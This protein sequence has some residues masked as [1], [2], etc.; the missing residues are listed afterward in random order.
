[1]KRGKKILQ[2]CIIVFTISWLQACAISDQHKKQWSETGRSLLNNLNNKPLTTNDIAS[3]LKQALK[4]GAERVVNRVGKK[5]GYLNDKAIHIVLPENFKKIHRTLKKVGLEKYTDEL[6]IKMNRAA[7]VA[8]QKAKKLFWQ[9]IKDMR[10][11]DVTRIYKGKDDAATQYFKKKMTPSLNR[12]I[13]PVV[14][15]TM[16]EVGV[17]QVY[18]KVLKKYHTIPF[19][20][21][22]NDDLT[23][24]VMQKSIYGLFYYL[25]REEA[26]IRKDPAKRTTA[27]LKRLFDK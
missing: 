15:Q 16:A 21:K 12:L 22:V 13:R 10:W 11:Q 17:V 27:L 3:G 25:A 23:G 1:M 19:V 18:N 2:L 7:E 26:A 9:A 6:E 8:A 20:P 5:N 4:I 14:Q 24:Y